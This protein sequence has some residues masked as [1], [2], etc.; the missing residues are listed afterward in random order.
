MILLERLRQE[1]GNIA[2]IATRHGARNIRVFGSVARNEAGPAS[3]ID[4][5]VEMT[6]DR[7]LIDHV[8]L[9]QDLQELLGCQVHVVTEKAL[10][11]YIRDRVVEEAVAL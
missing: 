4:F 9:V 8:A 3:D 1:K 11:W 2:R 6:P 7:S 5:L 10:H